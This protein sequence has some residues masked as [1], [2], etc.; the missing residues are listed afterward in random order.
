[1]TSAI[2]AASSAP[3]ERCSIVCSQTGPQL[4]LFRSV[5]MPSELPP[6]SYSMAIED[7]PAMLQRQAEAAI[8]ELAKTVPPELY[9]G[10]HVA[11]GN[12]WRPS[13]VRPRR[14]MSI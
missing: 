7:V 3:A 2:D 11:I 6:A 9:A 14:T 5:G 10:I 1:M 8:T 12:P 13:N 4:L